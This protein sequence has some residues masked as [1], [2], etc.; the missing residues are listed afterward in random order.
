[1]PEI[2]TL[3]DELNQRVKI[4]KVFKTELKFR[5]TEIIQ[6]K[7][8]GEKAKPN[9]VLVTCVTISEHIKYVHLESEGN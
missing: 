5:S 1:M 8:Q 3:L 6:D 4:M 2:K 9:K 7:E